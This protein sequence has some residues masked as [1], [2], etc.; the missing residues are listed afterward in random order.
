GLL[1]GNIIGLALILIQHYTNI[2]PLDPETYYVSYVPVELNLWYILAINTGTFI[3][4]LMILIIPSMI[5]AK[6]SPAKSIRFE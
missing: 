4:S 2:I 1:W 6:I 3:L 5:I